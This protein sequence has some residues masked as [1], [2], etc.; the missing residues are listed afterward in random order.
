MAYFLE[1]GG[2]FILPY[3]KKCACHLTSLAFTTCVTIVLYCK[4]DTVPGLTRYTMYYCYLLGHIYFPENPYDIL[5]LLLV[6]NAHL[7]VPDKRMAP[8]EECTF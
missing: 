6:I 7:S 5:N 4:T 3:V 1:G 8:V 2:G